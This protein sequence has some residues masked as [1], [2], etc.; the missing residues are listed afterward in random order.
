M[1]CPECGNANLTVFGEQ[2]IL[3]VERTASGEAVA[4]DIV[5]WGERL[6]RW[7]AMYSTCHHVWRLPGQAG[8]PLRFRKWSLASPL[9]TALVR[10]GLRRRV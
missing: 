5:G 1:L 3:V 9:L 4:R 10:L 6:G 8:I 7:K 2:I